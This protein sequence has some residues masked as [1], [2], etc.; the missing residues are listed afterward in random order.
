MSAMKKMIIISG[1]PRVGANC[2][3]IAEALAKQIVTAGAEAKVFQ[4]RAKKINFC[5]GCDSCKKTDVCVHQDDAAKLIDSIKNSDG[6]MFVSPI[7]FG[8][9]PGT[10]KTLIDRFYVLFNPAKDLQPP[11][12]DKKLGIVLSFG[13]GPAEEYA[14]VAEQVAS[15][16][17]VAGLTKHKTVLCGQSN[18]PQKF[19]NNPQYQTE[20]ETLAK[21]LV[22]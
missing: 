8:N 15:C 19:A 13:G 9:I 18:N 14:K 16:F 1:S 3:T 22:E 4:I 6:V 21:W 7:Y 20:V 17:K 11:T 10:C 2:D 5:L 12:E